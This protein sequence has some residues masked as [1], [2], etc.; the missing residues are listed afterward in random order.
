MKV[1]VNNYP[2]FSA[3]QCLISALCY[4]T[5]IVTILQKLQ[6]EIKLQKH[7]KIKVKKKYDNKKY[8]LKFIVGGDK[9]KQKLHKFS[10]CNKVMNG[11]LNNINLKQVNV[12][13][14]ASCEVGRSKN[15]K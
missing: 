5:K 12:L 9:E 4:K 7:N 8:K 1:T 3:Y 15:I 11:N 10:N 14:Y 2:N 6:R 13:K